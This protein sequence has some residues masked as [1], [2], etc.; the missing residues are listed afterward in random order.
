MKKKHVDSLNRIAGLASRMRELGRLRLTALEQEQATLSDDL[1]AA[2]EALARDD[3]AYGAAAK[4]GARRIRSLQRRIDAL[5]HESERAER[6]A[7]AHAIRAKLA[8]KVAGTAEQAYREREARK[9]LAELVERT[10][11]KRNASHG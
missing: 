7:Q 3:L 8:D 5:E 11:L 4:L 6:A 10:L 9:E 1:R 2:F